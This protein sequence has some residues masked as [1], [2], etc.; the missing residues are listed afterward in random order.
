MIAK[1]NYFT[2]IQAR[3]QAATYILREEKNKNIT[4]VN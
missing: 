3:G 4:P 2:V 1:Q